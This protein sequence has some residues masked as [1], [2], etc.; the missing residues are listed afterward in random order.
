M[1]CV[2]FWKKIGHRKR[3]TIAD[4]QKE[5]AT[6]SRVNAFD[7]VGARKSRNRWIRDATW[8]GDLFYVEDNAANGHKFR[9][10]GPSAF[11]PSCREL[12][13]GA[14][15]RDWCLKKK[16]KKEIKGEKKTGGK[17]R[18][19]SRFYNSWTKEGPCG[20]L[21]RIVKRLCPDDLHPVLVMLSLARPLQPIDYSSA[22]LAS[23][24][25]LTAIRESRNGAQK[26]KNSFTT[27]SIESLL[28]CNDFDHGFIPVDVFY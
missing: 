15:S 19:Y 26:L 22:S 8:V 20:I 4:E 17:Q 21:C 6:N 3:D 25:P 7:S 10:V 5:Q 14:D 23:K 11:G 2:D 13:R 24:T 1:I 18:A 9:H 12:K 16:N 28:N 27:L